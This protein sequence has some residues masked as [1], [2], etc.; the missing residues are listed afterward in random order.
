MKRSSYRQSSNRGQQVTRTRNTSKVYGRSVDSIYIDGDVVRKVQPRYVDLPKEKTELSDS[1]RRNREKA[2]YMSTGYIC[3]LTLMIGIMS[4]GCLWY[5][6][7]RSE[8]TASQKNI[9]K[10]QIQLTDLKLS[11][12]EEYDRIMGNVD[13]EQIKKTAMNELG[14]KYPD[15]DQVI[16]IDGSGSDYVRQYGD[17]PSK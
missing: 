16:N 3:F 9:S 17:I 5:V 6:N 2:K 7:L 1:A 10:M 15:S 14:M 13:L 8:I 11:N 4:I 12:D